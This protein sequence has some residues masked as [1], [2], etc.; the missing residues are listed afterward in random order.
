MMSRYEIARNDIPAKKKRK[1]KAKISPEIKV[2]KT[3]KIPI[4]INSREV[5][6]ITPINRSFR[7][8]EN[9]GQRTDSR[10][11]VLTIACPNG[12]RLI[13]PKRNLSA[14][15]LE[16]DRGIEFAVRVSY[17][18]AEALMNGLA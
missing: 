10:G 6:T 3:S 13:I 16:T 14:R 8:Y 17:K 4:D 18:E 11:V 7:A 12:Y 2:E 1:S 5:R 9:E 15:V